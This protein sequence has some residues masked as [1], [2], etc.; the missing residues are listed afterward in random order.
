MSDRG[1]PSATEPLPNYGSLY[2]GLAAVAVALTGGQIYADV[3]QDGISITYASLW[4]LLG[5]PNGAGL[6][7]VSLML[8]GVLVLLCAVAAVRGVSTI[9]LPI[10]VSV[11]ALVAAVMLMARVGTNYR[12]PAELDTAG[13]MLLVTAWGAIILGVVH[14]SHLIIFRRRLRRVRAAQV[15]A[16]N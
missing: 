9:A 13:A 14:T 4:E 3:E 7:M 1:R 11:L 16:R 12:Y 15:S 10:G 5:T 2:G 6:A 8:L